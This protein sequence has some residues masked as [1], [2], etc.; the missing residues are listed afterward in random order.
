MDRQQIAEEVLAA[1]GGRDNVTANDICM[2]RLRIKT[3]NPSLVDTDQLSAAHGVLGFVKRGENGIEVVFGPGKVEAVH[4]ALVKLTGIEGVDDDFA[5][6]GAPAAPLH[7]H[8]TQNPLLGAALAAGEGDSARDEED[9]TSVEDL[10]SLL[11]TMDAP[12]ADEGVAA[13]PDETSPARAAAPA[14]VL[15]ING[16]NI[17]MLGIR[18]PDIYGHDSYQDMLRICHEAA[19]DAGFAECT[20]FQSNHEGDL[21]DAIQDAYGSY[22]GIVINPGAYTHTSIA[23]LDAAKAVG[24]PMI[25]IHISKVDEREEF[26]KVSYI[27]AACFETIAGMGVEGYRKAMFDMAAHL[28]I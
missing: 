22:A 20:C 19:R 7:V 26:R 6:S 21:I 1:V 14:R 28:G 9:E 17:N 3:E 23:I 18:E 27:R 4:E 2:T 25:E 5:G 12:A 10:V 11:D 13:G 8:I 24:L 15:V 16:P